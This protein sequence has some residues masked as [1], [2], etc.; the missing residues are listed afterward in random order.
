MVDKRE[1]KHFFLFSTNRLL[2]CSYWAGSIV[3]FETNC[4]EE[5]L[6]SYS[7]TW[8]QNSRFIGCSMGVS[9]A[10]WLVFFVTMAFY[11]VLTVTLGS[12]GNS[13]EIKR[14]WCPMMGLFFVLVTTFSPHFDS[15]TLEVETVKVDEE[16]QVDGYGN[17]TTISPSPDENTT[18]ATTMSW[19]DLSQDE[20]SSRTLIWITGIMGV[21][22][23]LFHLAHIIILVVP[24]W[25]LERIPK[26]GRWITKGTVFAEMK[27]KRAAAYKLATM[28]QN[29]LD[30]VQ[31]KEKNHVIETHY[32]QALKAYE[33]YGKVYVRAGGFRWAWARILR[34]HKSFANEGV[35]LPTRFVAS[36]IVR[37]CCLARLASSITPC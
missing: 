18:T 32:G 22:T 14:P 35:W 24:Q 30:V 23:A 7:G 34:G 19:S 21:I 28:T 2:Y 15:E 13:T 1:T 29:A 31:K 26:A 3:K 16:W 27:M 11:G 9:V 6:Y 5:Y 10:K 25:W 8:K 37:T 33:K 12:L 17:N 36:N 20:S 4:E